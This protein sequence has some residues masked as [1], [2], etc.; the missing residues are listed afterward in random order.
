MTVPAPPASPP[1]PRPARV[2]VQLQPQHASYSD[3]RLA[4]DKAEEMGTDIVFTW[5]HF[6]PLFGEPEG[7][8]FEC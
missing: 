2:A 1:D 8:H 7:K 6:Y 5:D 4:C 3:I